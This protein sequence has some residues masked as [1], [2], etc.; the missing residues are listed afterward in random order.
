MKKTL[1][2]DDLHV[3]TIEGKEILKGVSLVMRQSEIHVVMGPNGGGKSTLA[4]AVMGHPDFI[5]TKGQ[6]L[7]DGKNITKFSPDRRAKLGIFLGFQYPTEIPGV[8]FASFLRMAVNEKKTAK[9]KISP[10]AFR[11]IMIQK[12]KEL[13]LSEDIPKRFLNESFSGGEKKKA[14]ILQMALLKP[15]FAILDEP[16]SGLDVDA[17]RYISKTIENLDFPLG[18]MLIT[19]YQRIFHYLK[20]D[21]VHILIDG[22][23]IKSGDASLAK[24]IEKSGYEELLKNK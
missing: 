6:I 2:I 14:E 17:L 20:P 8:N 21:F 19:H 4:Q 13:A 9:E 3:K 11:N 23:I 16:D 7:I 22:K 18:I 12:A 24:K 10:I 15:S 1:I 5:V